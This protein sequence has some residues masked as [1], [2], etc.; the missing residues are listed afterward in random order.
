MVERRSVKPMVGGS[1]P[2]HRALFFQVLNKEQ[3]MSQDVINKF[4]DMLADSVF[5]SLEFTSFECHGSPVELIDLVIARRGNLAICWH[6]PLNEDRY[7]FSFWK[8][9]S[10]TR[11]PVYGRSLDLFNPRRFKLAHYI[12]ARDPFLLNGDI[13]TVQKIEYQSVDPEPDSTKMVASFVPAK[14]HYVVINDWNRIPAKVDFVFE[15]VETPNSYTD[16]N[17]NIFKFSA[18]AREHIEFS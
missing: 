11:S 15:E 7:E 5:K 17:G 12:E 18:A 1:S 10:S 16:N 13:Y 9:V 3:K 2:P 4:K 8:D 14:A 6:Y